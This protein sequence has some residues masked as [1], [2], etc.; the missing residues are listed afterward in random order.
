MEDSGQTP[1]TKEI[2]EIL[3]NGID[4]QNLNRKELISKRDKSLIEIL[5]TKKH[6]GFELLFSKW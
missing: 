2:K 4:K 3:I 5:K 6:T 1:L